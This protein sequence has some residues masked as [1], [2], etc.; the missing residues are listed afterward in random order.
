MLWTDQNSKGPG[1]SGSTGGCPQSIRKLK[2]ASNFATRV[3]AYPSAMKNVPSGS[4]SMSVGRLKLFGPRPGTPPTPIVLSNLPSLVKTLISCMSS[5]M[6]QTRFSGSYGLIL[7]L[8]GPRD[9]EPNPE[10]LGGPKYLS[11]CSH[12]P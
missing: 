6:I 4:Q 9:T 2:L 10:P 7:I 12:S 11:R 8:C 5:S 3:P 1:L